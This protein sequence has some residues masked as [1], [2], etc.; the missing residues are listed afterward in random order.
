MIRRIAVLLAIL[1]LPAVAAGDPEPSWTVRT[2]DDEAQIRVSAEKLRRNE[3]VTAA[4]C[5]VSFHAD[6]GDEVGRKA[7]GGFAPVAAGHARTR[8]VPLPE[9][10]VKARGVQMVWVVSSDRP[11]AMNPDDESRSGSSRPA[12]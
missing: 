11:A 9:G 6:D 1:L 7:V 12:E 3:H 5:T 10:A 8:A 4:E 2:V